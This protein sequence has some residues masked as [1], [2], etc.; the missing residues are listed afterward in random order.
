MLIDETR[1]TLDE[2]PAKPYQISWID[3]FGIRENN[4]GRGEMMLGHQG[5]WRR[6][7][8]LVTLFFAPNFLKQDKT[9]KMSINNGSNTQLTQQYTS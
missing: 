9:R 1:E 3:Y 2:K 5:T 7:P 6:E 8:C 4:R